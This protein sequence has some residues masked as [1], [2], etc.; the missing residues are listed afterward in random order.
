VDKG[1]AAKNTEMGDIGLVLTPYLFR[2]GGIKGSCW[3]DIVK[4]GGIFKGIKPICL[5]QVGIKEDC[6]D[7]VKKG[8]VHVLHYA[9]VL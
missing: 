3:H 8:P 5:R 2:S 4:Q 7:L 1:P 6:P 9:I